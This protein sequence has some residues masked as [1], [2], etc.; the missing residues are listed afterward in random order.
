MEGVAFKVP[1]CSPVIGAVLTLT[2]MDADPLRL[3]KLELEFRMTGNNAKLTD[4]PNMLRE[5]H[6]IRECCAPHRVGYYTGRGLKL[7]HLQLKFRVFVSA[8]V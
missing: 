2:L 7:Q 5:L 1:L 3:R 6:T 8:V 4:R